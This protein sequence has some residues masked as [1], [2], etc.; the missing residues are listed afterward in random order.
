MK[1]KGC[2]LYESIACRVRD[3]IENGN[4][5]PG[6]KLLSVREYSK[7]L[8]VSISTIYQ[9]Y[10]QLEREGLVEAISKSGFYVRNVPGRTIATPDI[11]DRSPERCAIDNCTMISQVIKERK[12]EGVIDLS[13]AVPHPCLL[14]VA[15]LNK[16]VQ[17][18][19]RADPF[20]CVCYENYAG[21]KQLRQHICNL[22]LSWKRSFA[23]SEVI[24][25]SGCMEALRVSL[26]AVTRPGDTVAVQSPTFYGIY[27]ILSHLGLQVVELCDD[28]RSGISLPQLKSVLH[29]FDVKAVLLVPNFNNPT[30]SL[31][32][33]ET[34]EAIVRLITQYQIPLLEDDIYG[35][36]FFGDS[37]PKTCKS[38]D[39]EGWVIYCSSFSKTLA[40]GYRVG[41]CLPGRFYDD[42]LYQKFI[43]TIASPSLT[44]AALASYLENGRY[45]LH[46]KKMRKTL[47]LQYLDYLECVAD[48]FPKDIK[49]SQ[50]KGGFTL[51][52]ELD[53]AVDAYQIYQQAAEKNIFFAPGQIF[54]LQDYYKNFIRI[55]YGHPMTGKIRN[56][57]RTLGRLSKGK[58]KREEGKGISAGKS[59]K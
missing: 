26:R 12:R 19:Y 44:Q 24:I 27:Q 11:P 6:D 25:T 28:P 50:P 34:K 57:I 41:W 52:L 3:A 7:H 47:F 45:E 4:L 39:G 20:G 10:Y 16:A 35:E 42:V 13:A 53:Q 22:A 49:I 15:K 5:K 8:G 51:W 1:N 36:L 23:A 21:D 54:S 31:I 29:N 33:D 46:L 9:A 40:P 37:R 30:G 17:R 18:A 56:G 55:S 32:P 2:F 14:P 43:E 38:F 58:G 48:S 59:W